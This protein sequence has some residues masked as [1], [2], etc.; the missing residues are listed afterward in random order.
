MLLLASSAALAGDCLFADFGTTP[1]QVAAA[2]GGKAIP[3]SA[4]ERLF[5]GVYLPGDGARWFMEFEEDGADLHALFKFDPVTGRLKEVEVRGL[6]TTTHRSWFEN[7]RHQIRELYGPEK[8]DSILDMP[9]WKWKMPNGEVW[10]PDPPK[11]VG[12]AF[13]RFVSFPAIAAM[14]LRPFDPEWPPTTLHA[15]TPIAVTRAEDRAFCQSFVRTAALG[16]LEP[17]RDA[18]SPVLPGFYETQGDDSVLS[19]HID[20]DNDGDWDLVHWTRGMGPYFDGEYM[21]VIPGEVGPADLAA[22]QPRGNRNVEGILNELRKLDV[23]VYSGAA[24]LYANERDVRFLPI[25]RDGQTYLWVWPTK[26]ERHPLAL[27]YRPA[28]KG[29]LDLACSFDKD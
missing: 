6:Y 15:G 10:M 3:C 9:A 21:V 2:S 8:R 12:T 20:I 22:T 29:R 26:A 5:C 23:T 13:V 17:A 24:T 27:L 18:T 4:D 1:E 28:A 16:G 7:M 14:R 19:L 11:D 25:R